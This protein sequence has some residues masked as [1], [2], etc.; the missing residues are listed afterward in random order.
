MNILR[1]D[2]YT[3]TELAD[4]LASYIIEEGGASAVDFCV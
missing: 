2:F 1:D 4:K 3:P